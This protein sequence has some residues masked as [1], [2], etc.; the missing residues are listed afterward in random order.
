MTKNKRQDQLTT[1]L[2]VLPITYA[3]ACISISC[4]HELPCVRFSVGPVSFRRV[5]NIVF[6]GIELF[7]QHTRSRAND[8]TNRPWRM[9]VQQ[10]LPSHHI[11]N[12]YS[13][14]C[15]DFVFFYMLGVD[16][17]MYSEL[18]KTADIIRQLLPLLSV[19]VYSRRYRYVKLCQTLYQ[20]TEAL[21]KKK[22][23]Q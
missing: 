14:R 7:R 13:K 10:P 18:R 6:L 8:D 4:T 16:R 17:R 20:A 22:Y 21:C 11:V 12:V 3:E 2:M 5:Y 19:S 15:R 1:T 9:C 23:S